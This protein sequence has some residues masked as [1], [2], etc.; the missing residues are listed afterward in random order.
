[1]SYGFLG[2]AFTVIIVSESV[3]PATRYGGRRDSEATS[4]IAVACGWLVTQHRFAGGGRLFGMSSVDSAK[5]NKEK[6]SQAVAVAESSMHAIDG[7]GP[8]VS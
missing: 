2:N 1:V 5:G 8:R 4:R 3:Q 6:G 7:Q